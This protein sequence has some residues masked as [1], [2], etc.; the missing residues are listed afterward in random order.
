[1]PNQ[2]VTLAFT[3]RNAFRLAAIPPRPLES[4]SCA[5]AAS[6]SMSAGLEASAGELEELPLRHQEP[7][8][9]EDTDRASS[10]DS[11]F[12]RELSRD[13]TRAAGR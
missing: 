4:P 10:P 11:R 8:W 6:I 9:N 1:M 12:Q 2:T 7:P 13:T 3:P 5:L